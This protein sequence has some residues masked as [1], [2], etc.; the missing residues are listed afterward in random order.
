MVA[1][2]VRTH[3][4]IFEILGWSRIWAFK[5]RITVPN[6]AIYHVSSA[7]LVS[8]SAWRGLRFPG[9]YVPG[10]IT[11]GTFYRNGMKTFWDIRS[12]K[13]AIVIDLKGLF[14]DRLVVEVRDLEQSM[15]DLETAA[16]SNPMQR[17]ET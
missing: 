13:N 10:V 6:S 16:R 14:Y 3:H 4:T 7:P 17:N 5:R 15:R 2:S 9:T 8:P 12:G 11:A 1:I